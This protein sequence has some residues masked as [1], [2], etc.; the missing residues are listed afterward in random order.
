MCCGVFLLNAASFISVFEVSF[1][2][3]AKNSLI[4]S[5]V[6][7]TLYDFDERAPR[8]EREREGERERER[9]YGEREGE[10]ERERERERARGRESERERKRARER[11]RE[12]TECFC[13][14]TASTFNTFILP[15][16]LCQQHVYP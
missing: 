10:R 13:H 12:S 8:R 1:D 15:K 14:C 7:M 9:E 16:S 5:M 3:K 6:L 2:K 4:D 11:E